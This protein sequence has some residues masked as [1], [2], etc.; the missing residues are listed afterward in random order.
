MTLKTQ[1]PPGEAGAAN[2]VLLGRN[3]F[4]SVPAPKTQ[5]KR[6]E[7]CPILLASQCRMTADLLAE[8]TEIAIS[9]G[10]AILA[11]VREADD[12]AILARFKGFDAAARTARA[13]AEELL[14]YQSQAGAAS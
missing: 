2:E 1:R 9:Y 8:S 5:V 14:A 13:C 6:A 11:A 4:S 10:V 3:A 7:A 12:D